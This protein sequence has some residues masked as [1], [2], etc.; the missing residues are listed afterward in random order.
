MRPNEE[1]QE[2]FEHQ[3]AEVLSVSVDKPKD[4]KLKSCSFNYGTTRNIIN[5]LEKLGK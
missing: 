3:N 1:H 4:K 2:Y 5:W